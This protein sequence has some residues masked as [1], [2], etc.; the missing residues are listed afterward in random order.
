MQDQT[1]DDVD[2]EHDRATKRKKLLCSHDLCHALRRSR[3]RDLSN[4][5]RCQ[6]QIIAKMIYKKEQMW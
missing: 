4:R 6:S 3:G 1:E 5:I 2:I